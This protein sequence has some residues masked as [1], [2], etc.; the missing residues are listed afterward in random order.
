MDLFN[1]FEDVWNED[2]DEQLT[3]EITYEEDNTKVDGDIVDDRYFICSTPTENWYGS[4]NFTI[5][6]T[7]TSNAFID[8][9]FKVIVQTINDAPVAIIESVSNNKV[10]EGETIT[11]TGDYA[12]VDGSV[13]EYNWKSNIDGIIGTSKSFNISKL[14]VGIHTISLKVKDDEGGI[15]VINIIINVG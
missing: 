8:S 2:T 9:N 7:D 10:I 6:C 5:R 11:F 15:D 14:S 13:I 1:F 12:D 4:V 3:F